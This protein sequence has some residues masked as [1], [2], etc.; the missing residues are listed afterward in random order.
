MAWYNFLFM[1]TRLSP[2]DI[3]N[4]RRS[5]QPDFQEIR[6]RLDVAEEKIDLLILD[7]I[8]NGSNG[9]QICRDL[10]SNGK[11]NYF[12]IMLMSASP[13]YLAHPEVC[14]ADDIIEKPFDIKALVKKIDGLLKNGT[15]KQT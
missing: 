14:Q 10:K 4:I 2:E 6:D 13:E 9:R 5:L 3:Q 15:A 7:V 1:P 8:L 11:T 12:P